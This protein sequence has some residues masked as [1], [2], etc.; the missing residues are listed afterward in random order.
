[1]LL[2]AGGPF[3][4]LAQILL[5]VFE[6]ALAAVAFTAFAETFSARVRYSGT[7]LGY[8]L[9]GM[10]AGGTAPYIALWLID[11]T[12]DPLSPAYFLMATAVVTLA[13]VCSLK[14]TK[15]KPLPS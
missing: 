10:A 4:Y 3:P 6:V 15:N 13:A 11:R 8:N 9:A 7:A 14:E 1:M 5:G 2:E 12:G